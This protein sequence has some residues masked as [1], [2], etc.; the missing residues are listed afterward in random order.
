MVISLNTNSCEF[1]VT[2][3]LALVVINT[4]RLRFS[5]GCLLGGEGEGK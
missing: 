2:I 5:C 3:I 1:Q 4:T